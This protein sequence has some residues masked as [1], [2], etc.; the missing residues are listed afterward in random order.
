MERAIYTI[1]RTEGEPR[2][3]PPYL[4]I[5][6]DKYTDAEWYADGY[7]DAAEFLINKLIEQGAQPTNDPWVFPILYN[8]IHSLELH[9]KIYLGRLVN[10]CKRGSCNDLPNPPSDIDKILKQHELKPIYDAIRVM[11]TND[12]LHGNLQ[13]AELNLLLQEIDDHGLNAES[14]RYYDL[15]GEVPN[16]LLEEQRWIY[17]GQLKHNYKTVIDFLKVSYRNV[18]FLFCEVNEFK[19]SSLDEIDYMTTVLKDIKDNSGFR[20]MSETS[21][22]ETGILVALD[23]DETEES[24]AQHLENIKNITAYIKDYEP[25]KLLIANRGL[26]F[27]KTTP[28]CVPSI[29]WLEDNWD[30]EQLVETLSSQF[31]LVARAIEGMVKHKAYIEDRIKKRVL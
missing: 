24:L 13:F 30:H 9:L 20:A 1:R 2:P 17:L 18:D 21:V 12:N 28:D 23:S 22:N 11:V 19:Q 8:L 29:K 7:Y 16:K 27:G 10:H 14:L 15:R 6:W 26:R 25:Q 4:V 5:Y 31:G 3:K